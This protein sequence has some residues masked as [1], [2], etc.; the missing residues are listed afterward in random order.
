M[1][2][3]GLLFGRLNGAICIDLFAGGGGASEG[4]RRALGHGPVVAI[5]H[6]KHAI[7]M[8]KANHPETEHYCESVFD[9]PPK[10]AARGRK[11]DLLWASPDCR[12]FSRA[13]GGKPVDKG[14]RGLA[15][16]V[17][18]WAREVRPTVICMENVPEF[19]GWGPLLDDG[20]PDK[21][22]TGETFAEFTGQLV[23]LGYVVEHRTLVACDYGAPTSR[24]R[25]Y[26]VA[27]CDGK[28]IR[29][30]E[31]THGPGRAK[32]WLTAASC[33]DWSIPMLSIFATPA[34]AKAWAKATGADGVPVRPL[35]EATQR[36]IAEGIR[37]FVLNNPRPF[38]VNLSHG[39][40]VS[41]VSEP[42]GTLTAHPV[43]GDRCVVAPVL[44]TLTHGQRSEDAGEPMRTVT[45]AH[46]GERALIAPTLLRTDMQSDGRLRG[47]AS[48]E[49]PART[50]TTQGGLGIAAAVLV[51]NNAN[52]A[53]HE[54]SS[55]L[56]TVT[57]G[58][59]HILAAGVLVR[60]RSQG[61][62]TPGAG[63]GDTGKPAPTFTTSETWGLAAATLI[64]T[65]NG[66]RD[67]QAPRARDV[68][69]P[70]KTVC[71]TGSP[72][73]V[74]AAFLARHFTGASGTGLDQPTPTITAIDHNGLTACFLDKLHGSAAAGQSV[75]EPAPTVTAQ[76]GHAALVSAFLCAY[77]GSEKDGQPL[78]EPARTVT[79]GDR[80]GL[81]TLTIDGT[82]YAIV[83]IA[84]RMLQPRELAAANGWPAMKL[85]GTKG[86]QVA[87]IGNMV[88]P[89]VAEALVR[90]NL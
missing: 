57:G 30:P 33:I 84:M 7:E 89:Q 45:G 82:E 44:Q 34:E 69:R 73:G 56:G 46:R 60:A 21:A 64:D 53:P 65:A 35:A 75:D 41:P 27:R 16:A 68:E 85:H 61:S 25:L 66:E 67:G 26:L 8:H 42:M 50:I 39:G 43:G 47:V 88:V 62:D 51:A 23:A 40:R 32:P 48:V 3:D 80:F 19:V 52:N 17:V 22:R 58:G 71:S 38:L 9:V 10:S 28:P 11:I 6:C 79:T 59:R 83:D 4:V 2:A 70:F 24:K 5:N 20:R 13:K 81:V 63:L 31:P 90:A 37:R 72:G 18:D 74:V 36:R 15:W 29:W 55:P 1:S 12:H 87:R 54:A 14:I 77:Y 78:T 49:E 76:G 86:D